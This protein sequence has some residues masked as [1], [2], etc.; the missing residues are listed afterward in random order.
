MG[1][2][3]RL[4]LVRSVK[5]EKA[6]VTNIDR[7]FIETKLSP[8]SVSRAGLVRRGSTIEAL[9]AIDNHPVCFMTAPAGFGKTCLLAEWRGLELDRGN[10]VAWVSLED[11]DAERQQFLSYVILSIVNSGVALDDLEFA[12]Q[13]GLVEIST[14]V[15][16]PRL[17]SSL[18][19]NDKPLTLILDDYHCASRD[20]INAVLSEIIAHRPACLRIIVSSRTPPDLDRAA[21]IAS[22]T[23]FELASDR[24]RFSRDEAHAILC[25]VV[26]E[27]T[28]D[29]IFEQ[30]EGWPIAIQ[31]ARLASKNGQEP[32]AAPIGGEHI[33]EYFTRQILD[34][35]TDKEREFLLRTSILERFSPELAAAVTGIDSIQSLIHQSNPIRSLLISLDEGSAWYRYHHLFSELLLQQLKIED[36]NVVPDL[37]RKA[38]RWFENNGLVL[39]AVSHASQSGDTE[40]AAR[41]VTD[42]GGWALVLYGG[43]GL[44]RSLLRHFTREEFDRYP[45]LRV[46]YVYSLVKDGDI[47]NAEAELALVDP[48]Q[49]EALPDERLYRDLHILRSLLSA[50]KDEV[51]TTESTEDLRKMIEFWSTTDQLGIGTL[52]ACLALAEIAISD[53][54]AAEV[55]ASNGIMSMRQAGSVLGI[56]YCYIHLGQCAFYRGDFELAQAHFAEAASMA[57]DNFGADSRLQVN[58]DIDLEALH[59]WQRPNEVDQENLEKLVVKACGTDSWF[60]IYASGFITLFELHRTARNHDGAEKLLQLCQATCRKRE[61]ARLAGLISVFKLQAALSGG[62]EKEVVLSIDACLEVLRKRSLKDQPGL[63]M[64]RLE[65]ACILGVA[66]LEMH[67]VSGIRDVLGEAVRVAEEIGSDF[68]LTRLLILRGT[69]RGDQRGINAGLDDMFRAAR[70]AVRASMRTPF[71]TT[72]ASRKYLRAV[73]RIARERPERRLAVNFLTECLALKLSASPDSKD[74][75]LSAREHDVLEELAL[76]KSN[77]EIA[78]SLD[79][80][81]HTVKFHLKNIFSKLSV[82]NRIAAINTGRDLDLI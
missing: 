12:A 1:Q 65:A 6:L 19:Q 39:D 17:V 14:D 30:T 16:V 61:I 36:P 40:T 60:D 57:K 77:K 26:D 68:Y 42:A 59:F 11:G 41:I 55:T 45:R 74:H 53:F 43:V 44:I 80:T 21:L 37:H 75:L 13:Q 22:G 81:D 29:E 63:W 20:E 79:M 4:N 33:V 71:C 10:R 7:W 15:I 52:K 9:D 69:L 50:Y 25:D 8:P 78:R 23:A 54:D 62:A 48:E 18:A 2:L 3:S 58:C 34:Q 73:I 76:G 31:L 32:C 38:S 72:R 47:K 35:F 67:P 24:L 70:L 5:Q 51:L 64:I 49:T 27:A 46:A 56:N 82:E 66:Q 28:R